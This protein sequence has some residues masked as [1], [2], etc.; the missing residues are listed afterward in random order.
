MYVSNKEQFD[1]HNLFNH[2]QLRRQR[3][4][5]FPQ[6]TTTATITTSTT[7]A[8]TTMLIQRA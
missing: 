4:V 6:P 2:V 3:K 8:I 5:K 1:V 7:T